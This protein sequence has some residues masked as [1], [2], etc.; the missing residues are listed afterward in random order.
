MNNT[1]KKS[2]KKTFS[3]EPVH[4]TS[5]FQIENMKHKI[6]TV[7][8]KKKKMYNFKNIE[9]FASVHDDVIVDASNNNVIEGLPTNPIAKFS[10]DDF[11]GGKDDI[12]EPATPPPKPE[13]PEEDEDE[14]KEKVQKSE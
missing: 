11:E 9:E 14:A 8:K 12:Y 3:K 6:R 4:N 10:D 5:E 7:K 13:L 1:E 2:N